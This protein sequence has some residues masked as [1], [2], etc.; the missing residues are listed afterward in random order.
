MAGAAET[1][2]VPP[3]LATVLVL[4]PVILAGGLIAGHYATALSVAATMLALAALHLTLAGRRR[5]RRLRGKEP[6]RQG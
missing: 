3:A 1:E 6:G 4:T 2:P 5:R